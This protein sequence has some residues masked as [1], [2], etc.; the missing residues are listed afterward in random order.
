MPRGI[1]GSGDAADVVLKCERC[2]QLRHVKAK[3]LSRGTK[4][5]RSC[6]GFLTGSKHRLRRGMNLFV[7]E[8]RE[9]REL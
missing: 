2:G 1:P 9:D 5:C 7:S 6:A 4:L 3:Q 8:D